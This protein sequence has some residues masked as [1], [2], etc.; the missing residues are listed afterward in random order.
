[1]E[2]KINELCSSMY[3]K[4][5]HD[6]LLYDFGKSVNFINEW[7]CHILRCENQEIAKQRFIQNLT[8][9][10]VF[11]VLDWAM[12]FLQRRFREK[13]C[14][15]Y[16]KRGMNWHV[17]CV[18]TSDGKG[19]FFVSFYN[20]IFNSCS[21]DWFSV[22]SI[23]ESLLITVRS[24][25]PKVKKAYLKSDEAGCYHNSQLIVAARDVGERVGVSLQRYDF[26]EPQSGKDVCDRI[27]CPLKGAIRRYCNEGH[28]V[29]TAS[30]MHTALKERP[31]Q[32]CTAA[33][34]HLS[35]TKKDLDIKKFQQFSAMHDF[36]YQQDGLRVWKAFQVGPG[37]LIPWDEIYM[38]HQGT[39][40]LITE[41]ENFGF[42][43][44]VT[45]GSAH[46]CG[47]AESSSELGLVL[48]CP[49]PAC[50]RTF[51]SVE[52]MELHISIGQ[53]T[54]SV[55][56]KLKRGWV[57]KFSSLT[58]SEDDSTNVIERQG[59]EPFQSSLSEG[60]ALHKPKGGAVRFS[61]KVRQYLTSKFEIGEQSGRKED[62]GQV[63]Q[64]MRK[65]KGEKG[66]RL[67][68]R[69]E[70]LTKAQIQGFFSRLSSS[71]RRRAGPSASTAVDDKSDEESI[72]EEEVGH[73]TT[74]ESVVTE[75]GLTHPIVYDIYDLC[76]YV[77]KE[78]L[79]YFTVSMLK[80]ICT[81]YE[82]PFKSR[83]SK[84]VLMSKIKEMTYE[85]QCSVEG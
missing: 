66:E 67:F 72:D 24:S 78:K 57:E 82:L 59:S 61:E 2:E 69:E 12:K 65:A 25:N 17:S 55:Y 77:K 47:D 53:H 68:S 40:D 76:D 22:L 74:V 44:R 31:V 27:L 37:K 58:L 32:G 15:W 26:S 13:Q 45:H 23:L 75:I 1:M 35:E 3:S 41:H 73:M 8:E 84:A 83:D 54:E 79:N 34:C 36:S 16:A 52:E 64:D 29:L 49:E 71:R 46:D 42:I 48:E 85:C 56:D 33:V 30:D 80:E 20:H 7:K 81:F 38:K 19:N 10:S 43:P 11:I 6:D 70:W 21:Q 62:P 50:A 63:S 9:D 51:K 28:D 14:D 18:I 5:Q 60:W 39:T 4:E